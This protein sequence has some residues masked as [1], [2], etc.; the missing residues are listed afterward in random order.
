M[1]TRLLGL[2]GKIMKTTLVCC[3]QLLLAIF[4]ALAPVAMASNTWYVNGVE[5][6]NKNNCKSPQQACKTIGHAI[7]LASSGDTIMVAAATYTE[8][9]SIGINLDIIGFSASTTI[10]DGNHHGTVVNISSGTAHVTVSNVTIRNGLARSGGGIYNK[11]TLTVSETAVTGNTA[12][13]PDGC[14]LGCGGSGGGISNSGTLTINNSAVSG[15]TSTVPGSCILACANGGGGISNSGTLTI[16]KSTVSN[17]SAVNYVPRSNSYGGGIEN[18]GTV[19][20][21]NSTVAYNSAYSGGGIDN[22]SSALLRVNNST[23]VGNTPGGGISNFAGSV[24]VQN[25]I[26]A[27]SSSDGNCSGTMTSHGYNLSSDDTCNFNDAGDLNNIDPKL[28]PLQN[29]GGPTET[30][31]ELE[32]SLTIDAGN[33]SG[34]TDSQGHLLKTDQRGF[35]RPGKDKHDHRCDMGAYERQT[36]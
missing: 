23:V 27:F 19:T 6:R 36:D 7:S 15:N 11:G 3:N 20:L 22:G 2:K 25:S 4:L 34:C 28:G 8:H 31:A 18:G 16:N 32:G 10:I 24:T 35:P 9:L 14:K 26:F 5:G 12:S 1:Q 29:N 33:P 17:N 13:Q 30:I 21:T